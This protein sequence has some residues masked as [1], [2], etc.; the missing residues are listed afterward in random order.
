[1]AGDPRTGSCSSCAM[2]VFSG[3]YNVIDSFTF[4]KNVQLQLLSGHL[5]ALELRLDSLWSVRKA[6]GIVNST[7]RNG[8]GV[9]LWFKEEINTIIRENI[10][11]DD[12]E[13]VR[14]ELQNTKGKKMLVGVVN[15][16]PN[17]SC[18]VGG[19]IKQEIRDACRPD[20]LRPRV[21]NEVAPE[22]ADTLVI[23]F[24]HSVDAGRV[25]MDWRVGN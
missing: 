15:R 4:T 16:P 11:L 14:V 23:I 2:W 12:V 6:E 8:G 10:S 17:S 9:A 13:S 22:I 20:A 25:P 3:P 19:C 21:L 7:F 5:T 1:M 24:Q 18:D